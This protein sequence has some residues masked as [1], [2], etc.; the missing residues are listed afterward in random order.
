MGL[1]AGTCF[2]ESVFLASS[3]Q[4]PTSSS[5][6]PSL[7]IWD[8]FLSLPG[9]DRLAACPQEEAH[10]WEEAGLSLLPP[11]RHYGHY[12]GFVVIHGTDTMAFA[13]SVLSFVLENLQKT[14]ILTGAQVMSQAGW[15]A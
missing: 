13:A 15:W 9:G 14:V 8:P 1:Q 11:Q 12:D 2:P 3:D 10:P 7:C 4:D 6:T 5:P